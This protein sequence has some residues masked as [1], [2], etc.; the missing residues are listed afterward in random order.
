[1]SFSI[2]YSGNSQVKKGDRHSFACFIAILVAFVLFPSI[3]AAQIG[4]NQSNPNFSAVLDIN[5]TSKGVL[6]PRLTIA[7]RDNIVTAANAQSV[8]VPAGL[9]IFCT[10]CCKNGKGS[11]Y[12]YNGTDWKSLDSSCVDLNEAATCFNVTTTV[13]GNH[14]ASSSIPKFIDGHTTYSTQDAN[15]GIADLRMH[16][17]SENVNAFFDFPETVPAGYKIQLY[18][19]DREE[20]NDV[21][22]EILPRFDGAS[23][24]QDANT[25]S[26]SLNGG[27]LTNTGND[28]VYTKVLTS[29]IN[30]IRVYSGSSK[31]HVIF[32]EIKVFN[33][34]DVE[35]S[36]SCP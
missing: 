16:K 25:H 28:Y 6:F 13:N 2:I 31:N 10:N 1:M 12:S 8:S 26:P 15:G 32:L 35:M 29:D 19:N 14:L 23:T 4:I 21:G 9:A 33:S 36:L 27:V 17:R 30:E 20:E 34:N 11:L 18:F 5:S 24:G 7:Q 3:V 22:L